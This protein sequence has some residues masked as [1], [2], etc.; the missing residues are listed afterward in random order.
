MSPLVFVL[1]TLSLPVQEATPARLVTTERGIRIERPKP[2]R[3]TVLAW[4]AADRIHVKFHDD[5]VVRETGGVLEDRGTGALADARDT[6]ARIGGLWRRTHALDEQRLS[7]LRDEARRNLGRHVSD[8]RLHF[9]LLLPAGDDAAAAID[10]FNALDCVEIAL[11]APLPAPPPAWNPPA[12]VPPNL[13]PAQGYLDYAPGGMNHA[14]VWNLPGGAGEFRRIADLE[15]SYNSA[16]VELGGVTTVLPGGATAVVDPFAN[17][18]HGTAVLGEMRPANN[19][20]GVSGAAY[21][22]TFY[23]V[24]TNTDLGYNMAGAISAAIATLG[25]GDVILIEQQTQGPNYAPPACCSA[26]PPN[27][28]PGVNCQAGLVPVEWDLPNYNAI[29]TAVGNG[30]IVVEAGCNGG[31]N[32]DAAVY[33]TGHGGHWPFLAAND[34]GAILVGAGAV[35]GGSDNDRSRLSFSNYGSTMDLQAWGEN[36]T[37]CGY[38]DLYAAE[39]QNAWYTAVFGGTSS[40]SPLVAAACAQI[41]SIYLVA[42][43]FNINPPGLRDLLRLTGSPQEA[44]AFPVTQSIGPRPNVSAAVQAVGHNVATPI[45]AGDGFGT[46]CPCGNNSPPSAWRGCQNSFG[47]GALLV[48]A[49]RASIAGDSLVLM[50]TEMPPSSALYFQG[51]APVNGGF[52][53][54]F[55]DGLRCAGGAVVR[56]GTVINEANGSSVLPRPGQ[57]PISVRGMVTQPGLRYY[58]LWYRNAAVYCTAATFNLTNGIRVNWMP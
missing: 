23:F 34:S 25:A 54:L 8:L 4:H 29:V 31:Q 45:C 57:P 1:A 19:G 15:Y 39:G 58:Q 51:T 26:M 27:C 13:R 28:A 41:S 40:A 20:I 50:G 11:P 46:P 55:G 35:P 36:V 2:A 12:L 49:G 42:T 44:G 21:A 16:H 30:I 7:G 3:T 5:L 37:T 17:N 48:A 43:G 22:S 52:G 56:L 9:D 6:L 14:N 53:A 18:A 33:S 38:G 10:A 24:P 47:R 32:L